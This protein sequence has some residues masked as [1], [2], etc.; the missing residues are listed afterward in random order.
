MPWRV[1]YTSLMSKTTMT[2]STPFLLEFDFST[3][4]YANVWEAVADTLRMSVQSEDA[5]VSV[6]YKGTQATG[7]P[8]MDIVFASLECAKA[9]TYVYLGFIDSDPDVYT[10]DEVN[11]Y[12]RCGKFVDA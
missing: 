8:T 1:E 3:E 5:I 9:F 4:G 11:E 6:T 12:I 7:W 10:D 2:S